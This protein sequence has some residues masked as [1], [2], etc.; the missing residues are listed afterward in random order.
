MT[1]TV[2][3]GMGRIRTLQCRARSRVQVA[4]LIVA[5]SPDSGLLVMTPSVIARIR[6]GSITQGGTV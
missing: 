3:R 2:L 4:A 5:G 6:M 1:D